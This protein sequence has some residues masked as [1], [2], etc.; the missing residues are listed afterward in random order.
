[1]LHVSYIIVHFFK[2]LPSFPL[3]S[4]GTVAPDVGVVTYKGNSVWQVR[5][6]R[7]ENNIAILEEDDSVKCL[8]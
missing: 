3:L 1:M 4:G 6:C 2:N 7:H 8:I 5:S